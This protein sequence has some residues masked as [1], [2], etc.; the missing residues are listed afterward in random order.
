MFEAESINDHK[1][2]VLEIELVNNSTETFMIKAVV[3]SEEESTFELLPSE[4][5]ELSLLVE[6]NL[7]VITS[8]LNLQWHLGERIGILTPLPFPERH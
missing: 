2:C 7:D 1:K 4:S 3:D 8:R 6:R 5:Y